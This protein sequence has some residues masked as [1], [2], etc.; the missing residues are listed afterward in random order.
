MPSLRKLH[1]RC[2]TKLAELEPLL[3]DPF[4]VEAMVA[5]VEELRGR[6]VMLVPMPR[7]VLSPDTACGLWLQARVADIV[8]YESGTSE[9]HRDR[10][11]LHE[12]SH[13]LFEHR[14]AMAPEELQRVLPHISVSRIARFLGAGVPVMGRTSYG[15]ADEHEAEYLARLLQAKGRTLTGVSSDSMIGRLDDSLS[16]PVRRHR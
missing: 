14:G 1:K 15:T 16:H 4:T 5:V 2:T 9:D 7:K 13:M 8:F 3:P 11:V 6:K 10:I 12:L